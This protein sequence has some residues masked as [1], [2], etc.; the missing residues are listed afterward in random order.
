MP[1]KNKRRKKIKTKEKLERE[2][3]SPTYADISFLTIVTQNNVIIGPKAM[4]LKIE[5]DLL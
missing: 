1:V 3:E 2:R 4:K 5:R